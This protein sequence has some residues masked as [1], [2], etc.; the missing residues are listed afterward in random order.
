MFIVIEFYIYFKFYIYF[1][2]LLV[3]FLMIIKTMHLGNCRMRCERSLRDYASL[4]ISVNCFHSQRE[5]AEL[6]D[7]L[8][9]C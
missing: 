5:A 8:T 4:S 1:I 2:L 6:D 9:I 3:F 7:Y